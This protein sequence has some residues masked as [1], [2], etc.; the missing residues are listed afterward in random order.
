MKR[1]TAEARSRLACE[2]ENGPWLRA[3]AASD[4]ESCG[5]RLPVGG[6][7]DAG[8]P[9]NLRPLRARDI[10]GVIG[11][12]QNYQQWLALLDHSTK[13][14]SEKPAVRKIPVGFAHVATIRRQPFDVV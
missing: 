11:P 8:P 3:P 6:V 14:I 12:V 1:R 10:D 2:G 13:D 9:R 7:D 5:I 4:L